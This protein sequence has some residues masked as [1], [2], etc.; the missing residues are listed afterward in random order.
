MAKKLI[1]YLKENVSDIETRISDLGDSLDPEYARVLEAE[2]DLLN[3]ILD[4][5][6][7]GKIKC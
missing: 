1:S 3:S 5:A 4:D 7:N 2:I 6:R